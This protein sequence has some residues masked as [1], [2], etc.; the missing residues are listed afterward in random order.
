MGGI[1][2]IELKEK[3]LCNF[4][5]EYL[6]L[7]EVGLCLRFATK[8]KLSEKENDAPVRFDFSPF[9]SCGSPVLY[10]STF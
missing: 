3:I 10:G 1:T 8:A 6:D 5:G 4:I 9:S 2:Q 7:P